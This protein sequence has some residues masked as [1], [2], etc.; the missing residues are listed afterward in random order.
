MKFSV[1]MSIYHKEKEDYFNKTMQSIWDKQT[2]KPNE[3]IL[4]QDGELTH[5]LYKSINQWKEKL[6][7]IF[8]V[9]PLEKNV[10]LASALNQGLKHCNY[11]YIARMD[12]DDISTP[13]RFEKQLEFLKKNQDIDV[14]GTYIN[15]IDENENIVKD[16]VKFPLSHNELYNFFSKRDPLA[17]PTT[18]FRK[19]YFKKAGIYRTDLHLAEDTL[20]WYYG[21]LNN[22]RFANIDYIGLNF[23]RTADFYKRRGDVK[24]SIGLLKYRL[25]NINR[26][27]NY[28]RKE[29]LF[30]IAY[31]IISISPS[32]I[33]KIIYQI[34]R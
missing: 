7:N 26:K 1:L 21:F 17:H 4:V 12:T 25:F 20:L 33:K 24:K 11:E 3:I 22:C 2:I 6:G 15:E 18:M 10:G 14:V 27:L 28:G 23:R 8:K 19:S 31:F 13:K 5:E 29:D 32:F 30:A 9:I 34:L 16:I